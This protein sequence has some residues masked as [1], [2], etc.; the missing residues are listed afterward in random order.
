MSINTY[1]D[2]VFTTELHE[3]VQN[4]TYVY[5]ESPHDIVIPAWNKGMKLDPLTPEHKKKIGASLMGHSKNAGEK[6]GM[7]GKKYSVE[8]KNN[9]AVNRL[10][11]K[12]PMYGKKH[13][14]ENKK[15]WSKALR[16]GTLTEEHK[17]K[18]SESHKRY[19]AE[20]KI[21]NIL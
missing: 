9:M 18:I 14:E 3:W 19:H 7:Y 8:E 17:R 16:G 4:D 10:G 21:K 12:N 2:P 5:K 11:E 20:R 13:S 6:N 1:T 15:K